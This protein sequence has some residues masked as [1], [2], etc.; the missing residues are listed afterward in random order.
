MG[1]N[2]SNSILSILKI[3]NRGQNDASHDMVYLQTQELEGINPFDS[4]QSPINP[5]ERAG[6][7]K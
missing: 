6:N 5:L 1:N 7:E 3:Q 2:K 4:P